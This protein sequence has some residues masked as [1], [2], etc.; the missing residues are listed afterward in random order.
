VDDGLLLL[1]EKRYDLLIRAD[2]LRRLC[3]MPIQKP[4]DQPLFI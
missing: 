4:H 3:A 1:V 2:Q